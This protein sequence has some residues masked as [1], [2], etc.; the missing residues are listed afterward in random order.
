[1]SLPEVVGGLCERLPVGLCVSCSV[2]KQ[3]SSQSP[4]KSKAQ[5]LPR[6]FALRPAH[7]GARPVRQ[8]ALACDI[9]W[10][11]FPQQIPARACTIWTTPSKTTNEWSSTGDDEYVYCCLS[12]ASAPFTSPLSSLIYAFVIFKLVWFGRILLIFSED[13]PGCENPCDGFI[14]FNYYL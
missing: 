7:Y 5:C 4:Y 13:G 12:I 11:S 2:V 1:M 10:T 14:A 3:D 9:T 8:A 6:D